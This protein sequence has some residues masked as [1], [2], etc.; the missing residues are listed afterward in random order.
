M[1]NDSWQL[2]DE[3]TRMDRTGGNSCD[4]DIVTPCFTIE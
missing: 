2:F 1:I 4:S 3:I